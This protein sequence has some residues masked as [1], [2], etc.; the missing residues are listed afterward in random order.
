[1]EDLIEHI[2]ER[3]KS[4]KVLLEYWFLWKK[5]KLIIKTMAE[6]GYWYDMQE[7]IK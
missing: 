6:L 4:R 1:M 2:N 5:N 7:L 3:I